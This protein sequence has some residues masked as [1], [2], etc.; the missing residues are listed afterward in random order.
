M[1]KSA[2]FALLLL[3]TFLAAQGN[4]AIDINKSLQTE[5]NLTKLHKLRAGL[6]KLE[7]KKLENEWIKTYEGYITHKELIDRKNAIETQIKRL[8]NLKSLTKIQ[9][10]KL[11][12]LK[13]QD[14]I[15]QDKISLIKDFEKDPFKKLISPPAL[16][17]APKITNPFALIG[18]LSYL[19]ELSAK[20]SKYLEKYKNL[21]QT[22][23]LLQKRKQTLKQIIKLSNNPIDKQHLAALNEEIKQFLTLKDIFST[24]KDVYLKKAEELKISIETDIKKELKK[25]VYIAV[26]LFIFLVIF[27]FLKYL[28]KK[29]L[30]DKES[31]Y[32]V[33]KVINIGFITM[34]LLTLLFAYIENVNYLITILGFASAG[35]AIAM[36][37]WFMSLMGWFVI[38]LGGA[39]HIGDRIKI[40]KDGAEYVGDVV[41]ISILRITIYEDVTLTT[42]MQNRRA[43]RIIFIPNNY[44]FT[45]MIANYSHAE[46]KTVWDGIDFIITFD[47]NIARASNIAKNIAKQYSKGYT[48]MTRRQ[49]S[50][51]RSKYQLK[52]TNV[53]PKVFTFIEQYGIKI[54]VWYLTNSYATLTLRGSISNKII[55]E[56][57]N[58]E[59]IK[60][61]YPT[62]SFYLNKNGNIS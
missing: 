34:L 8:K 46:L 2:L 53:E 11:K 27:I 42:Y 55:E 36:K 26:L 30:A 10:K 32:T 22:I 1:A 50:Q 14:K 9:V 52:N 48:D 49:L 47:S 18:G 38:M 19:K 20:K 13:N 33:N 45:D 29:Y 62:Q 21:E 23:E 17:N 15:L 59:D 44:I 5:Q 4:T 39:I 37:D 35:I 54:S 3:I 60:L 58:S 25:V 6:L 57:L 12:K 28:T 56:I 41:D 43:G 16:N 24:T 7:D 61:A 51:L 31:F 40:V